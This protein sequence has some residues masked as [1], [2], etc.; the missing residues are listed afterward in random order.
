[1]LHCLFKDPASHLEYQPALFQNGNKTAGAF[2]GR[3]SRIVPAQQGLRTADP[4]AVRVDNRLV[5]Q[6]ETP[7]ACD[8]GL[9]Q[10][11]PQKHTG[12]ILIHQFPRITGKLI[13]S[14]LFGGVK[15]HTG[16]AVQDFMLP[17]ILRIEAETCGN[18]DGNADFIDLDRTPYPVLQPAEPVL[19]AL[20]L[21]T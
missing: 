11:S 16:V 7:E 1:M 15:G 18:R 21:H 8:D 19:Y 5:V 4:A 6:G 9:A 10:I 20:R 2:A 17:P 14:V 3:K 13:L 12:M